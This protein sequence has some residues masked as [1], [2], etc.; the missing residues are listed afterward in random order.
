[1]AVRRHPAQTPDLKPETIAVLLHGWGAPEAPEPSPHGFG[2]GFLTLTEPHNL[3]FIRL[4]REHEP[5]LRGVALKWSWTPQVKGPDGRK[6]FYAEH[7]A[8]G[9]EEP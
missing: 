5:W 4:W 6:R 1:M 8:A 7:L 2:G 9:Y 3:G